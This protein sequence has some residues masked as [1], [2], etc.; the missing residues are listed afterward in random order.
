MLRNNGR[1]NFRS[2]FGIQPSLVLDFAGTGTLDPRVTFTRSTTATYYNSSGVL[3]TAAINAPR[4][5][6]NPSTLAPLGLLIEQSSTNLLTYSQIFGS[7]GG[8]IAITST[9]VDNQAAAPDGTITAA[10]WT[11]TT[12]RI[13]RVATTTSSTFSIYVKPLTATAIGIDTAGAGAADLVVFNLTSSGSVTSLGS[14]NTSASITSVGNGWFRIVV[15]RGA[16]TGSNL[17]INLNAGVSAGN[18]LLWGAQLEAL[19]FPTSYIS[20]T[21]AQVTRVADNASMTGTNFSGFYNTA[22]GTWFAQG[23]LPSVAS[24]PRFV[25][26]NTANKT[27]EMICPTRRS[28]LVASSIVLPIRS[29]DTFNVWLNT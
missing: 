15:T 19:A 26:T 5:D 24:F 12:G 3:S 22:Q 29:C 11:Y 1:H 14:N 10:L 6:Y 18:Y 23:I 17:Y 16:T 13:Q 9:P 7:G 2:P 21:S 8:W 25:G 4:F 20:T 28:I 27:A